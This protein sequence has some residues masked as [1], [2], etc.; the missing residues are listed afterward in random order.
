MRYIFDCTKSYKWYTKLFDIW[1]FFRPGVF[2]S[3]IEEVLLPWEGRK[4]FI[5]RLPPIERIEPELNEGNV[6]FVFDKNNFYQ[7]NR[8]LQGKIKHCVNGFL[9]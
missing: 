8:M 6:N 2:P 9:A 4:S 1:K 7:T 3:R 5:K